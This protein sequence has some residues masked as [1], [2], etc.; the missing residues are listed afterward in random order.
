MSLLIA[1]G[2]VVMLGV[3]FLLWAVLAY[4]GLV[5]ARNQVEASWGAD[6]RAARAG[7]LADPQPGRDGEGASGPAPSTSG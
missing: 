3:L 6:R 5:K 4:N 2:I 7:A 1:L